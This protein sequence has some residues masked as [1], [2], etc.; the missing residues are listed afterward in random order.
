MK[1]SDRV[2]EGGPLQLKMKTQEDLVFLA[3][4]TN[5]D[6]GFLTCTISPE[7]NRLVPYLCHQIIFTVRRIFNLVSFFLTFSSFHVILVYLGLQSSH[8]KICF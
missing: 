5:V 7:V 6:C 4:L 8:S 2:S 3:T 1:N